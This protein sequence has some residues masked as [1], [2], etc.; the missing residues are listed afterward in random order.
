MELSIVIMKIPIHSTNFLEKFRP[1]NAVKWE[2]IVPFI[3]MSTADVVLQFICAFGG[4]DKTIFEFGTWIGRS[5]LGFSQNYKQVMT[6]DY[7]GPHDI[8]HIYGD[9]SSGHFVKDVPNVVAV[10]TNSLTFNFTELENMFDVVYVDGDHTLEGARSD[11]QNALR[12]VK[13]NGYIFVDDYA[14]HTMGVNQA[15]AELDFE[16]TYEITDFNIAVLVIGD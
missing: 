11:L 3:P 9:Y 14:N 8:G 16:N 10:N 4:P 15:V 6:I 7:A 12:L 5:A 2:N 13:Q 1:T